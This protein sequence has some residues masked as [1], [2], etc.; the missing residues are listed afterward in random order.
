[1]LFKQLCYY[2]V[3]HACSLT[4]VLRVIT[5]VLLT[6]CGGLP[7][8]EQAGYLQACCTACDHASYIS[9]AGIS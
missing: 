9:A 5:V 4:V 1:M 6:A 7:F 8:S 2:G 3:L